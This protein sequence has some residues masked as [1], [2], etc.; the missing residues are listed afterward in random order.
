[1][2]KL[3]ALLVLV[4]V[5]AIVVLSCDDHPTGL[6]EAQATTNVEAS[7]APQAT[8]APPLPTPVLLAGLSFTK[9]SVSIDPG[10]TLTVKI[11]CPPGRA[12]LTGGLNCREA[13]YAGSGPEIDP[14]PEGAGYGW[15]GTCRNETEGAVQV[16]ISVICIAYPTD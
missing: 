11:D 9:N 15:E 7:S 2:R 8:K 10:A 3:L 14:G 13:T 1:M 5:A 4:P 12:P 16:Q 6:D